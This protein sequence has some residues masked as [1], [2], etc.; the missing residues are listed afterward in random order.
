MVEKL[1]SA[2]EVAEILGLSEKTVKAKH[3]RLGLPY[4]KV[5]SLVRFRLSEIEAWLA[6]RH[7]DKNM[8]APRVIKNIRI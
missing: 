5:A 3:K 7:I 8:P 1:I 4:Y 2:K 6:S